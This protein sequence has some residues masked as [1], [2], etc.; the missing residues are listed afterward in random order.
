M[1]ALLVMKP[2]AW[3]GPGTDRPSRRGSAIVSVQ[4]ERYVAP[5]PSWIGTAPVVVRRDGA[6]DAVLRRVDLD[7]LDRTERRAVL[8]DVHRRAL[9]EILAD[10]AGRAVAIDDADRRSRT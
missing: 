4:L 6:L 5:M 9:V 8:N 1:L 2:Y 3:F 7:V 10:V